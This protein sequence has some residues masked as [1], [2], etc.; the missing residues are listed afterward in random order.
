MQLPDGNVEG[1]KG[2]IMKNQEPT[3]PVV[4]GEGSYTGTRRYNER[5]REH[6]RSGNTDKEAREAREALE[7]AEGAELEEAE[8]RAKKGPQEH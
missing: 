6:L 3:K 5:L 8:R 2:T 1:T 4:E 7:G